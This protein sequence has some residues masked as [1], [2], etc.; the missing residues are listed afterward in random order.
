MNNTITSL[1]LA[2]ADSNCS[3]T[4]EQLAASVELNEYLDQYVQAVA[5]IPVDMAAGG[6]ASLC[7]PVPGG[8]DSAA[9]SSPTLADETAARIRLIKL[10]KVREALVEGEYFWQKKQS[11]KN[12]KE[13]K[14]WLQEQEFS[15][16]DAAGQIK[17]YET[18]ANFPL[19]QIGWVSLNTLLALC[20]PRY[21]ELKEAMR[22]ISCWSEV[23]VQ[24][25]MRLVRS[26]AL[27]KKSRALNSSQYEE[28]GTGWRRL[29]GGGRA[30][31]L[32]LLHEDWLSTLVDRIRQLKNLTLTQV[33][34]ESILF[35]VQQ[36][37]VPGISLRE[38]NIPISESQASNSAE[39]NL[40]ARS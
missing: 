11:F 6:A 40:Y 33:I 10:G 32:P 1:A 9:V 24:E 38:L 18:F 34:K 2:T 21:R 8:R 7:P 14:A 3:S 19:E 36:G 23:K 30:L 4:D 5:P 35:F 31:Q 17:L 29:P 27:K 20:Q 28:P 12:L 16:K 26:S 22:A 25:L 37:Q 39:Y 15:W 13:F